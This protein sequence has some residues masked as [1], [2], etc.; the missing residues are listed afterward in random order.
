L[1]NPE[2]KKDYQDAVME[3]E[4]GCQHKELLEEARDMSTRG[5]TEANL[6]EEEV[7]Q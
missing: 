1:N 2:P 7:E 4:T 3:R 6:S 5:L